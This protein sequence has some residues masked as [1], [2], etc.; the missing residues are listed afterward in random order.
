VIWQRSL[1]DDFGGVMMS[2]WKFSESPLIDGDRLICTPGGPEATMV[3]LNKRTGETIWKCA[4]PPIGDAGKDGAGYSSA[5]VAE[6]AGV[7][8]YVQMLGRGVIGVDAETGRFLW[9]YNRI[10]N[11]VANITSPSCEATMYL[12]RPATDRLRA[13]A[14]PTRRRRFA[15]K[16]STSWVRAIS[17]TTTAA[18]CCWA[19]TST[20]ATARTTATRSA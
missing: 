1:P 6:L 20:A 12:P 16:K 8:Q 19:I 14:H 4:M 9:G 3:A 18:S 13:A 10:A 17:R 11:G 2:V 15:P 5:V 7:R